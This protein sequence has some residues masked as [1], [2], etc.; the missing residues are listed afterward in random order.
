MSKEYT[1]QL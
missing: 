1:T